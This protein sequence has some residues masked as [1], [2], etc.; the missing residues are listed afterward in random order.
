MRALSTITSA[1]TAV[2]LAFLPALALTACGGGAKAPV[3]AT[4]KVPAEEQAQAI[5]PCPESILPGGDPLE[6]AAFEGKPVVRV[7]VVGG[8]EESRRQAQKAIDLRPSELATGERVRADL[9]AIM[10][11]GAFDDA[12][13]YGLRVQAGRSVVLFY[14]VHDRPLIAEIGV[15]GAKTVG[16]SVVNA[17]LPLQ[18]GNPYDPAK[19]NDFAQAVRDEYRTSGFDSCRVKVVSEP[20]A[21]TPGR[22]RVRI[23]VDEGPLWKLTKIDFRGNK[24]VAP[25]ELKK[26]STLEI[27]QPFW[28]DRVDHAALLITMLYYDR[29]FVDIRVTP[30]NGAA[31]GAPGAVPI[32]FVIEEGDVHTIG[33][34]HVSKL[35]APV[36]KELV[37]KV[38]RARPKQ[39][40]S[41]SAIVEDIE[42][43][44]A[45]FT[46]QSQQV[47]VT[48]LTEVD[49]KKKTIDLT[50]QV[51]PAH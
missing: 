7:C 12:A 22:V 23:L 51:E 2:A 41:R 39:V 25:A 13:A 36:E 40:F 21:G 18:K 42:R 9:A 28:Q 49:K 8:T 6:A 14:A 50:F 4:V 16:D 44:K 27:G 37:E 29:G 10:K 24:R 31:A 5:P 45:Y 33:T 32:T 1:L 20:I 3:A 15:E 38:L 46:R 35:G 19:L 26:A 43:L 47:E 30:E 11:L 17:K 48:P 34:V